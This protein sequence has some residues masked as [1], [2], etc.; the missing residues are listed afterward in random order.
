MY[1]GRWIRLT[2]FPLPD[3]VWNFRR[4]D[5]VEKALLLADFIHHRNESLPISVDIDKHKV[6][7]KADGSTFTFMSEKNF[8]KNIVIK[9]KE[10]T[11]S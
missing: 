9:S 5:G 11:I 8:R 1:T 7:L 6:T 4:G 2:G 3:E 10:Y